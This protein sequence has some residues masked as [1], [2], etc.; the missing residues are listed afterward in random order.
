MG[1]SAA[2]DHGD[3]VTCG[4]EANFVHE[5]RHE[6]QA[7]TGSLV[8]GLGAAWIGNRSNIEPGA[9]I[10]DDELGLVEPDVGVHVG[11][12]RRE[13]RLHTP[14]PHEI[15][16]VALAQLI[17]RLTYLI[18]SHFEIARQHCVEQRFL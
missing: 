16:Y 2:H 4:V 8:N 13:R 3:F 12:S 1:S 9:L 5:V 18:A 10:A 15:L 17:A 6:D 11:H 14:S 7:A